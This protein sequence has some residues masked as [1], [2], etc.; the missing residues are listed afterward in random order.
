MA[1]H[2]EHSTLGRR[3]PLWR[4]NVR[5]APGYPDSGGFG[6]P[7]RLGCQSNITLQST[8]YQDT[9]RCENT[10]NSFGQRQCSDSRGA[11]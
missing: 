6:A 10:D 1:A 7:S 3:V 4:P 5:D 2:Y 11:R 9:K 8:A